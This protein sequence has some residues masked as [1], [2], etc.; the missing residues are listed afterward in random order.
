MRIWIAL[1]L[2]L[3][4]CS[5]ALADPSATSLQPASEI[6]PA[7]SQPPPAQDSPSRFQATGT[8]LLLDTPTG[9]IWTQT[10]SGMGYS[11]QDA[12]AYCDGLKTET[13]TDWRLPTIEELLAL[14]DPEST[15]EPKLAPQFQLTKQ[16]LW[17][18]TKETEGSA[19]YFHVEYMAP[20][21][22]HGRIRAI[23]MSC[24]YA[25]FPLRRRRSRHQLPLPTD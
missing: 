21:G 19:W 24:A 12:T 17:S 14:P 20:S 10:D 3:I 18:A 6:P 4:M 13:C 16:W 2:G 25:P 7:S 22:N 9:L 23:S 5:A 15:N 1:T 8:G 11:W